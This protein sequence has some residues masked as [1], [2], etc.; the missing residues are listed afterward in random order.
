MINSG[1]LNS[2]ALANQIFPIRWCSP[3]VSQ[4]I[5]VGPVGTAVPAGDGTSLDLTWH[6]GIIY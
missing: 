1:L 4:A 3:E 6:N 5:P 2:K